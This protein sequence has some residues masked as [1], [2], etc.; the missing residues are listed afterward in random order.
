MQEVPNGKVL[1]S[2]LWGG[3]GGGGSAPNPAPAPNPGRDVAPGPFGRFYPSNGKTFQLHA[4]S[5]PD[6]CLDAASPG[7]GAVVYLHKCHDG[8]N[9]KWTVQDTGNGIILINKQSGRALDIQVGPVA[10]LKAQLYDRHGGANQKFHIRDMGNYEYGLIVEQGG[11]TMGLDVE[12]SGKAPGT[13]VQQW[14]YHATPNQR[15]LFT[16]A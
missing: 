12:G 4:L 7:N 13:R 10:G 6:L 2:S 8:A 3:N 11:R 16:A 15:W 9:Q 14:T 1:S 5:V